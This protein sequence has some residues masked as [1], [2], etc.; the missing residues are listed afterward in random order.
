VPFLHPVPRKRQMSQA[1]RN[2]GPL[3]D[4]Q[5]WSDSRLQLSR[6]GLVQRL[7]LVIRTSLRE[8]AALRARIAIDI[9][10]RHPNADRHGHPHG[11]P[12]HCDGWSVPAVP[13]IT[14]QV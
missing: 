9:G 10:Y 2:D 11:S 5:C 12:K 14:V 8:G 13:D 1:S 3:G 7:R 6:L 4:S